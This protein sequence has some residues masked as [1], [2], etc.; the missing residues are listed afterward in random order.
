MRE[1]KFREWDETR[2]E[3]YGGEIPGMSYGVR[4]DYDDM[5]GF[6][7]AHEENS[8]KGKKRLLEQYIGLVDKNGKEIY[9]GDIVKFDILI[10]V[11]KLGIVVY[12]KYCFNIKGFYE[13]GFDYPT[14][15]FS[16]YDQM[17]FEVIGNIHENPELLEN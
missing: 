9:E 3:F 12:E 13:S 4:E 11:P 1:I 17:Q 2:A 6:R 16:E 10:G 5:V 14:L 7:F 8:F 15:A